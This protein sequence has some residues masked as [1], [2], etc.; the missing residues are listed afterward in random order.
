MM[1][2]TIY[3]VG[4]LNRRVPM[5]IVALMQLLGDL[6]TESVNIVSICMQSENTEIIQNLLA[7][8]IIAEIDDFY[9]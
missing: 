9:A 4:S 2:F 6:C 7:F 3:R 5:F 8:G 1:K